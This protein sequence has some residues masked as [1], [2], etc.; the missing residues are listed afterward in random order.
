MRLHLLEP[1]KL[2][3]K[4]G[5]ACVWHHCKALVAQLSVCVLLGMRE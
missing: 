3:T 2:I 4:G 5:S 1:E